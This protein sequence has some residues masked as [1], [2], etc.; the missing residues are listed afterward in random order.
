MEDLEFKEDLAGTLVEKVEVGTKVVDSLQAKSHVW[1]EFG[2]GK[3]VQ[4]VI[5]T[6]LRLNFT[7][8]SPTHTTSLTTNLSRKTWS[9]AFGKC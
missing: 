9:L 8:K 6:G 3:M 5:H 7:G 2:A 1:V 4:Q